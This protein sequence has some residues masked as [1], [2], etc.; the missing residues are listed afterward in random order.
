MK[1]LQHKLILIVFIVVTV[2]FGIVLAI[3]YASLS[4]YNNYQA[5]AVTQIISLNNGSMPDFQEYTN[6]NYD[7]NL[8]FV[9][10]NEESEYQ[11]RYF[12]ITYSADNKAVSV[13]LEHV[14][15]I[16]KEEAL[17]LGVQAMA[18]EDETGYIE[19][20]RYRLSESDS[21]TSAIFLDCTDNMSFRQVVMTIVF[22]ISILLIIL[23][24]L[25]FAICAKRVVQPFEENNQ[26]QKQFI[27]DASHELK[28][29]LSIISANAE[30]LQYK[31]GGDEWTNNIMQQTKRMSKL[32][33]DLLSLAKMD[34]IGDDFV[35]EK[36]DLSTLVQDTVTPFQEVFAQKNVTV[37]TDVGESI[38]VR[39]NQEQLKQLISVLVENASKYVS[40][41]G[42]FRITLKAGARRVTMKF[43]NTAQLADDL[44]CDRLF[45]RFYRPDSSRSSETG[46]YGIGLSIAQ[47]I[48]VQH[49]GSL[50]AEKVEDGI[51]FTAEIAKTAKS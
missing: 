14:A 33:N 1:K 36:V 42:L 12:V 24:T 30:V 32:I 21:G 11:T 37:E 38:V 7:E 48:A 5:D 20:Y 17:E 18:E 26:K 13:N 43:Y 3:T 19:Q 35:V 22:C 44:D 9:V 6:N 23:I 49:G 15:S 50:K 25:I 40:Q 46:G 27:T 41:D 34:E 39:G 29:P 45:D 28:T 10:M 4:I 8:P 51:C 2:V 47:K 16:T 31:N